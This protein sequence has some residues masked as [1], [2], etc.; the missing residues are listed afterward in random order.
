MQLEKPVSAVMSINFLWLPATATVEQAVQ[1]FLQHKPSFLPV[2]SEDKKRV[3]GVVEPLDLLSAKDSK[4]SITSCMQASFPKV[5]SDDN[6]VAV[7]RAFRQHKKLYAV[8]LDKYTEIPVGVVTVVDV[9]ASLPELAE[10]FLPFV[11]LSRKFRVEEN[12]EVP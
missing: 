3:L 4:A 1:L 10:Y 12:G 9:L 2:L 11:D 8:V 5:Y 6:L 7:L